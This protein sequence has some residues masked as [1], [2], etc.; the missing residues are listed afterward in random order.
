MGVWVQGCG[1]V[2]GFVVLPLA[3]SGSELKFEWFWDVV[4]LSVW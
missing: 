4:V 2:W 1:S 3:L